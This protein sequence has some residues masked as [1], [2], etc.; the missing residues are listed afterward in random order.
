MGR[1]EISLRPDARDAIEILGQRIRVA[2]HARGWTAADFG[3]RLGVSARTVTQMEKGAPT[4]SIG[5]VF[6]AASLLGITLFGASPA[7]LARMSTDGRALVAL[8]PSRTHPVRL[9]D[10]GDDF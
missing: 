4:T 5:H 8:L 7:E 2:R 1:Q 9:D 10:S 3:A 6:N